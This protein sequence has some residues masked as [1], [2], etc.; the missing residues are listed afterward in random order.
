MQPNDRFCAAFTVDRLGRWLYTVESWLDDWATFTWG[1]QRKNSAGQDVAVE[2]ISGAELVRAA[3]GARQGGRQKRRQAAGCG[4]ARGAVEDA[5]RTA[6]RRAASRRWPRSRDRRRAWRAIPIAASPRARARARGRRRSAARALPRLV[7]IISA[8]ELA[9]KPVRTARFATSRRTCRRRRDRLRCRSICRRSIRS[10]GRI[11]KGRNNTLASS[12]ATSAARGPSAPTEGGHKAIHPELGTLEDFRQ[13]GRNAR[14][15][16][17][18]RS[19]SISPCSVRPIIPGCREH[20]DWFIHRPD[21]TIQ[22]AENPPKKY[23]DIYPFNFEADDWRA[24][25]GAN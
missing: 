12:R 21:G 9:A 18:S 17:V 23:Q 14:A 24:S 19:R 25:M 4:R 1:L 8:L 20:P 11:A 7:R 6:R 5:G 22:Y 16:S 13:L 2:L 10:G 3:A 15:A